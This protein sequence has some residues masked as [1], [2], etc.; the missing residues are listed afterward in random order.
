MRKSLLAAAAAAGIIHA[1]AAS[2]ATTPTAWIPPNNVR[3]V[4]KSEGTYQTGTGTT[5]VL[6]SATQIDT[7][8]QTAIDAFA[9]ATPPIPCTAAAPCQV[10][11]MPGVYD[12]GTKALQM[13][14]YVDLVGSGADGTVVKSSVQTAGED[15]S[16]GTIVMAHESTVADLRVV[17]ETPAGGAYWPGGH[18]IG[19]AMDPAVVGTTRPPLTARVNRVEVWAGSDSVSTNR[20]IGVCAQGQQTTALLQNVD[21]EGHGIYG[22]G[23]GTRQY[24]G[25][26]LIARNSRLAGFSDGNAHICGSD[27]GPN[28]TELSDCT[29]EA[30]AGDGAYGPRTYDGTTKITHSR[31]LLHGTGG[32][33]LITVGG[34][35]ASFTMTDTKV[36]I[37]GPD[38][39]S[40]Y[41]AIGGGAF[42]ATSQ[43]PGDLSGLAGSKI[44]GCYD[45][46]FNPIPNQ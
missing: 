30:T 9:R 5:N 26:T 33:E 31:I 12:L 46:D 7:Q 4:Q 27:G 11:L 40:V 34:P 18:V 3:I 45:K 1:G 29:L 14:S 19:I 28:Y 23:N 39:G 24:D 15:C 17:N 22:Q 32:N 10:K 36:E 42:I 2:A 21:V 35:N 13:K 6:V 37:V 38:V 20:G 8:I 43:L 44:V 25:S 41:Q 16:T